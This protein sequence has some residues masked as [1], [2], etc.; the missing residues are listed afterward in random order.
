[1]NNMLSLHLLKGGVEDV[2]IL[3][4]QVGVNFS[5]SVVDSKID[6]RPWYAFAISNSYYVN[7]VFDCISNLDAFVL[8]ES[9]VLMLHE[10]QVT[11]SSC[12]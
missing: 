5:R 10:G 1:M 9:M 3:V 8:I 12:L 11:D 4:T 7:K 2:I 6:R